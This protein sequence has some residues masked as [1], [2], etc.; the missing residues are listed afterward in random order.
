MKFRGGKEWESVA[1][2]PS[3]TRA[4]RAHALEIAIL[5]PLIGGA[6]IRARVSKNPGPVIGR[7]Q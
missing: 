7:R 4:R 6:L 2:A 1:I 5:W 3:Q